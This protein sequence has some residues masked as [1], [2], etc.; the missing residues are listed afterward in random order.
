M[1]IF[2]FGLKPRKVP[3]AIIKEKVHA[4]AEIL[5]LSLI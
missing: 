4:A 3:K 1:I 5:G 2:A